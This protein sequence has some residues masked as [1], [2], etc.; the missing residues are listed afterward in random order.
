MKKLFALIGLTSLGQ[1]LSLLITPIIL[2]KIAPEDFG[3]YTF[4]LSIITIL[5]YITTLRLDVA[6]LANSKSEK[7]MRLSTSLATSTH[8]QLMTF[9]GLGIISISFYTKV[10]FIDG[11]IIFLGTLFTGLRLIYIAYL[12]GLKDYRNV[13][14]NNLIRFA[15]PA[16]LQALLILMSFKSYVMLAMSLN[17]V[18]IILS[19]KFPWSNVQFRPRNILVRAI[20]GPSH[21]KYFLFNFPSQVVS[22]LQLNIAPV[23][24]AIAFSS[25]EIGIFSMLIKIA[26]TPLSFLGRTIYQVLFK[27]SVDQTNHI[28]RFKSF[29]LVSLFLLIVGLLYFIC[30]YVVFNNYGNIIPLEWREITSFLSVLVSFGIAKTITSSTTY[31]FY[32]LDRQDIILK[33]NIVGLALLVI[34]F[35][36][37]TS[38]NFKTWLMT[39]SSLFSVYYV[40][41]WL[42]MFKLFYDKGFS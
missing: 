2:V 9:V 7:K 5:S 39:Y 24:L 31:V 10:Y 19:I 32:I 27:S 30:L 40:A 3:R 8:L 35:L 25:V 11:L 36:P 34:S 13:G 17:I 12:N 37:F 14:A 28:E 18:L 42:L 22:V 1:L 38:A 23:L 33:V 21:K 29:L 16:C 41:V 15:G 4:L 6:V 20:R 26:V